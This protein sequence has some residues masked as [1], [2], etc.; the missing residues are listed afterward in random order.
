MTLWGCLSYMTHGN[1]KYDYP[2]EKE[3][4][5]CRKPFECHDRYQAKRNKTCGDQSCT[6]ALRAW[7]RR[8]SATHPSQHDGKVEVECPNCGTTDWIFKSR[9]EI[10]DRHFCD[11]ECY[12]EWR[13][14]DP[15]WN[16]HMAEIASKGELSETEAAKLSERMTGENNPAWKGGVTEKKRKGNYKREILVRCPDE[17]S[18]MARANGYVPEHRLKVAKELGRPLTSE[19]CVHH[20]DHDNHNNDLDNLELWPNNRIHKLA[21]G[22]RE[23]YLSERLWPDPPE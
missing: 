13:S 11:Q 19:E 16:A 1:Q 18:E 23:A 8:L 7:S 4:V 22:D 17:L 10:K 12:N 20:I 21:E 3:C 2:V 6:N 14:N 5:I 9:A 15:D